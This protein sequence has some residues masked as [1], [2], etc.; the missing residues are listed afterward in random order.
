M[1]FSISKLR[2]PLWIPVFIGLISRLINLNV[3]IVGIHSWRQADTAAMA[4]HFAIQGTPIWLPQID[5][6]GAGK[7]FVESEF[8]LYPYILAQI[9]RIF[10][11]HE[12]LGRSL[13]VIFSILTIIILIKIG[14]TIFDHSS[15]WWG[16]LFFSFMPLSIYYGR[17]L[18]AEALL[19]LVSIL[20]IE[21]LLNWTKYKKFIDLITSWICF[22]IACL[23]KVLPLVWLGIPLL[24]IL[25]NSHNLFSSSTNKIRPKR[26]FGKCISRIPI[27]FFS[28]SI[29]LMIIWYGHSYQLG[30]TSGLSFGFWGSDSDRS[31]LHLIGNIN[32]WL[33][34]LLRISLRNT[35]I[36]GLPMAIIGIQQSYKTSGGQIFI[37]GIFGVFLCTLASFQASS[38]HEYYQLPLQI[39]LCPLM[40]K[41]WTY[42]C[43]IFKT[44]GLEYLKVLSINMI[45]LISLLIVSIDYWAVELR[46]TAIWMPLAMK[47]REEVSQNA[48]IVSVTQSDPTLLNLARRQGWITDASS[49]NN[50]Q[51]FEWSLQGATH[52]AGSMEWE[53]THIKSLN[54]ESKKRLKKII[55]KSKPFNQ[56]TEGESH[57]YLIPIKDIIDVPKSKL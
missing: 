35:A 56:C 18:Q 13:S 20:S 51:L 26:L 27:L 25:S 6:S 49:I 2:Y 17:T 3:P 29:L 7:G 30:A 9:Y 40:G 24:F 12:W 31:N 48:K 23:I 11:V 1:R 55:C 54:K 52:I 53:Q 14:T 4:R 57:T 33:D 36:L 38:I 28:G 39:F 42:C 34:L 47:I 22:S 21:R 45:L 10:G 5:W 15:G 44:K 50:Q 46:Q 16:G 32:V 19:L 41:G 43:I 8:P 37:L